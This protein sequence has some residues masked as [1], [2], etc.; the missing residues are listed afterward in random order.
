MHTIS[1]HKR[2]K[3]EQDTRARH[4][5]EREGGVMGRKI[6]ATVRVAARNLSCHVRTARDC[7]CRL[8]ARDAHTKLSNIT[9]TEQDTRDAHKSKRLETNTRSKHQR[10][11]QEKDTRD[12]HERAHTKLTHVTHTG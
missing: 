5:R 6:R 3:Q 9:H 7:L 8:H 4:M 10:R 11:T 1:R 2:R 12:A